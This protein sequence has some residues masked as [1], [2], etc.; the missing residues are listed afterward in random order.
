[1]VKKGH[2]TRSIIQ[3]QA[4]FI[5]NEVNGKYNTVVNYKIIWKCWKL[6]EQQTLKNIFNS[7]KENAVK[8]YHISLG[9]KER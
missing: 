5:K 1:M 6:S 8:F 7:E 2:M 9:I 3:W 4:N